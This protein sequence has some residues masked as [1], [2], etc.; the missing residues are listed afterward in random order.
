[1]LTALPLTIALTLSPSPLWGEGA[2][3]SLSPGRAAQDQSLTLRALH[4]RAVR[5]SDGSLQLELR[6]RVQ[7]LYGDRQLRTEALQLDTAKAVVQGNAPF[8]LLAPE[9]YLRGQSLLYFYEERRGRFTDVQAVLFL[10]A[11]SRAPRGWGT[12][13]QQERV[14]A[15]LWAQQLEGDLQRFEAQAIR[16][17]TCDRDHPDFTVEA[18]RASLRGGQR[19]RLYNA[20]LRWRGRTLL[21]IPTISLNL[22]ERR[23]TLELPTPT[24]SPDTGPGARYQLALPLGAQS[25]LVLN[26][27]VHTRAVPETRLALA[28]ALAGDTPALT[29]PELSQRLESSALYNLRITPERERNALRE[30]T[31]TL[32]LEHS[33][34]V[35][36]LFARDARLR[37]SRPLELAIS[38]GFNVGTGLGGISLRWGSMRERLDNQHTPTLQRLALEAEWLQPLMRPSPLELNLHLWAS[39]V[40]YGDTRS[41][42]WLRPQLELRYQ[43]G[44]T[45]GLMLG[46]ALTRMQGR[47]PFQ[48]DQIAARQEVALRGEGLIGNLRWGALLKY[49][50]ERNDLYDI[51]LFLGWRIHCIEPFLYWR[52]TPGVLLFGITLTGLR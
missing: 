4:S 11:S 3:Q 6:G 13:P 26:G 52:R 25:L 36:P 17:T 50:T 45:F 33:A 39:H 47:T 1:M 24:Y 5:Q 22:R 31:T 20:R 29:E 35:R 40:R 46:Y 16:A 44:E 8:E 42:S 28:V 7:L 12:P 18:A 41:F 27:A 9:G 37:V 10:P 30:R 23:E 14:A 2:N 38:T 21:S 32:R 19:L 49:D 48:S 15:R 51:Q 34:D 43:H